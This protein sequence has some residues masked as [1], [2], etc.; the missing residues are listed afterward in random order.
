MTLRSQE[1]G[2]DDEV[3]RLARLAH[4]DH[5]AGELMLGPRVLNAL[6]DMVDEGRP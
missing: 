1:V 3:G 2:R 4:G 5:Q 6:S